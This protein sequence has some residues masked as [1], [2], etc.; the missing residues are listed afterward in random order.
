M[1]SPK[2]LWGNVTN[3]AQPIDF[4]SETVYIIS[5]I[6]TDHT[7]QGNTMRLFTALDVLTDRHGNHGM[8]SVAA[9]DRD[10]IR[11]VLLAYRN[12]RMGGSYRNYGQSTYRTKESEEKAFDGT[13]VEHGE[14]FGAARVIS[15]IYGGG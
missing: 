8:I 12:D 13:Y 9:P 2:S 5:M 11:D 4:L 7:T 6:K 15:Y 1:Q 3:F 10:S 14:I